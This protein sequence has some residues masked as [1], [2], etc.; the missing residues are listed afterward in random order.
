MRPTITTYGNTDAYISGTRHTVSGL[1][2]GIEYDFQ[3]RAVTAVA[4]G[5]PRTIRATPD[6]SPAISIRGL[7]GSLH[8]G[9]SDRFTVS[10][11]GL[12][13]TRDYKIALDAGSG[14]A[15]DA[16]CTDRDLEHAVPRGE[17]AH[18]FHPTA[19]ACAPGS[20]TTLSAVLKL[21]GREV[22]KKDANIA[23]LS[24]P[25]PDGLRANG[26]SI[27]NSRGRA[28]VRWNR[29]D[30]ATGYELR[31][32]DECIEDQDICKPTP[33]SWINSIAVTNAN[34]IEEIILNLHIETLYRIQI[35]AVVNNIR[36]DWSESVFVYPTSQQT[37]GPIATQSLYA[38]WR[39]HQYNYIICEDT[40]PQNNRS[41]WVS[42]IENGIETWEANVVWEDDFV[43]IIRTARNTISKCGQYPGARQQ[44]EIRYV[45]R[46]KIV[47]ICHAYLD[48]ILPTTTRACAPS[49][50]MG[51]LSNEFSVANIFFDS[52]GEW[53]PGTDSHNAPCSKLFKYSI[54][55]SGHALGLGRFPNHH[56]SLSQ[57][58]MQANLSR[59]AYCVPQPYDAVALMGLY[60]S[61]L[62][63]P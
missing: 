57:S 53:L 42:E 9:E 2:N 5:A 29:V 55:E 8:K 10:V 60:Q 21:D 32:A 52:H 18:E 50:T 19:Y 17:S 7:E 63:H 30:A 49:S 3:V 11:S 36:S 6:R 26:H 14:L 44:N 61:H 54:H 37:K 12:S 62:R 38:H 28:V 47:D 4:H 58:V 40:F 34:T 24:P 31:Y 46:G 51:P 56:S 39:M 15:F 1:R 13:P 16:A 59:V 23:I 33:G 35:R 41:L 20:S 25:V 48:V 45:S 27:D 43:N 22:A